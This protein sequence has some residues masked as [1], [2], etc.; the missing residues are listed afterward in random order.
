MGDPAGQLLI[1]VAHLNRGVDDLPDPLILFYIVLYSV[2]VLMVLKG[3][4]G[5][6]YIVLFTVILNLILTPGE[7]LFRI[8]I[9]NITKEGIKLFALD[10]IL[11]VSKSAPLA[12]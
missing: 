12:V 10:I 1:A 4:K 11:P 3:L 5:I 8:W 7:V 9:I 2:P 6:F